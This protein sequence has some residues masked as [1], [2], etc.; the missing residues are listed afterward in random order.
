M[1]KE[2]KVYVPRNVK[3][4]IEFFRGFGVKELLKTLAVTIVS[5]LPLILIYK[6]LSQVVAISMF[7]ITIATT[8]SLVV[9]NDNNIS[10]LHQLKLVFKNLFMQKKFKYRNKKGNDK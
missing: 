6:Y 4:D 3:K 9:K 1:D 2:D 7:L 8:V 10:F 5:V